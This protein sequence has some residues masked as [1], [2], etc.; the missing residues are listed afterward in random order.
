MS[1]YAGF[2]SLTDDDDDDEEVVEEDTCSENLYNMAGLKL[3]FMLFLIFIV[4]M[5]EMFA[6]KW[7]S[8][9]SDTSRNLVLTNKGVMLASMFGCLMAIGAYALVHHGIV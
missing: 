1:K 7:L 2:E 4:V 6:D 5:G 8:Y 9:F 3:V